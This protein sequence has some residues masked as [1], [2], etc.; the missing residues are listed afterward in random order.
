VT[1]PLLDRLRQNLPAEWQIPDD[2]NAK[3]WYADAERTVYLVIGDRRLF[4]SARSRGGLVGTIGAAQR[5]G[6]WQAL[7]PSIIEAAGR[8]AIDHAR[9]GKPIPTVPPWAEKSLRFAQT[10][11]LRTLA[12]REAKI[13]EDL[14]KIEAERAIITLGA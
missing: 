4:V 14:A 11:R 8:L 10:R 7:R 6:A 12:E 9:E 13:R 1:P 5:V 2:A 3:G